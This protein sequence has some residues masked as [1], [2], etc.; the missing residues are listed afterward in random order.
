MMGICLHGLY[1][2]LFGPGSTAE[3]EAA[4]NTE[5]GSI[6]LHDNESDHT[7][8]IINHAQLNAAVID[9]KRSLPRYTTTQDE[10]DSVML[11]AYT[12]E[13][14]AKPVQLEGE[15]E[16]AQRGRELRESE[17]AVVGPYDDLF[18]MLHRFEGL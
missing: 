6:L 1:I 3:V 14:N 17:R 2:T 11:P 7:P 18:I 9:E 4:H 8:R 12:D 10:A 13:P 15:A 5:E 16:A